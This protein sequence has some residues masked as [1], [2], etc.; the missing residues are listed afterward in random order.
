MS[1]PHIG[2]AGLTHLGLVSL[3]AAAEK[4]FRV[5]GYDADG[6]FFDGNLPVQ[7]PGL[8]EA[9]AANRK[10]ISTTAEAAA[11]GK[12]DL[13]YVSADVSTDERDDSDL[14]PVRALIDGVIGVLKPDA[15]MV[16]LC[17]VPPGFTR[18]LPLAS[19]RLFCQ[20]ETLVIGDAM[21]RA[22]APERIILGCADPADP[23]PAVLRSYLDAYG[24]PVMTMGYES[25]E[26][27][28]I[29]VN[30]YLAGSLGVANVMAD[31][32]GRVG[33]D[34]AEITQALHADAR[35]GA[36]AYLRPGLGISG[37][38]LERDLATVSRLAAETGSDANLVRAWLDDSRHRKNWPLRVLHQ[39]VLGGN[40]ESSVA[41]LGLAYK[42]N[43]ASTKNAPALELIS[44]LGQNAVRVFDPAVT[45]EMTPFPEMTAAPS[46]LAACEGADAVV[47]MTPWPAFAALE[48]KEIAAAMRGVT[49][50]DPFRVLDPED[51]AKAGLRYFT[52]G[53]GPDL[54]TSGSSAGA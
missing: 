20:V 23:L 6:P 13:V 22:R 4:G 11:L 49:I 14:G 36:D 10:Q 12:C 27:A 31:L 1:A 46:A 42:E 28:K 25:A 33:A 34:W 54:P 9:L 52:L 29:A 32:C 53:R 15:P 45:P 8:E 5:T 37:G 2:F 48:P 7:E 3:A 47:I 35:I 30:A 40:P 43:T 50:L 51:C 16:V 26:L 24:C 21:A 19:E 18:A 38:N 17:Q 39:E 41:V 44:A